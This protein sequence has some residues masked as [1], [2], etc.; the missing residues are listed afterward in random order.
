MFLLPQA[1]LN[2]LRNLGRFDSPHMLEFAL[3]KAKAVFQNPLI[4]KAKYLGLFEKSPAQWLVK[5]KLFAFGNHMDY[6]L[7][8]EEYNHYTVTN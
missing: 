2:P 6:L 5:R 4:L 7:Q 1:V 3:D 8:G